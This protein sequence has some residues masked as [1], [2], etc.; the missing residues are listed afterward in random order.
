MPKIQL[1]LLAKQLEFIQSKSRGTIFRGGIGSGKT[2]ILAYKATMNALIGRH[3][4]VVS[5]SYKALK[6]AVMPAFYAVFEQFGLIEERDYRLRDGDTFFFNSGGN[7]LLRTGDNPGHLR[8]TNVHDFFIDEGRQFKD[9]SQFLILLGRIRESNDSQWFITSSPNGRDWEYDLSLDTQVKLIVQSTKENY[10]L[11][12]TYIEDLLRHYPTQF[13]AQE[14]EAEIVQFGTGIIKPQ[15]FNKYDWVFNKDTRAVRFW[16]TAVSTKTSADFSAGALC[17]YSKD[18][19]TVYNICHGKFEYPDLKKKII[20]CARL[21]GHNVIIGLE[22]V[23]QTKGFVDDLLRT[24]ELLGYTIKGITPW[25]DK[26]NRALPWIA[27]AEN[28]RMNIAN[29]GW[30][31]AFED[32]CLQFTADN[33]HK[34]DDQI[35][36]VSGSYMILTNTVDATAA[37]IRY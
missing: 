3:E 1:T 25:A 14:I 2:R 29:G 4:L 7:I 19:F 15:W 8:G 31:K 34:H 17:T 23:G 24:P 37:K 27:R 5:F 9:N 28:G 30:Y 33:K 21:D 36:A 12:H 35:D 20:E 11:P 13:A 10:F 16:D 18:Y 26:L 32:E 6:D 22:Q